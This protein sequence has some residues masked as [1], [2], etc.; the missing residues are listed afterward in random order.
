MLSLQKYFMTKVNGDKYGD[1]VLKLYRVHLQII[2]VFS[3]IFGLLY[4]NALLIVF[5]FDVLNLYDI[6][7]LYVTC[8]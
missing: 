7:R 8:C 5:V 3:K 6:D 1:L 2:E 4:Y